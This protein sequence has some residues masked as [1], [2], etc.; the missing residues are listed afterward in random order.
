MDEGKNII[1]VAEKK[2][3]IDKNDI[4]KLVVGS[5]DKNSIIF[6]VIRGSFKSY[7]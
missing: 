1:D 6:H 4:N 2:I 3:K 7:S 5:F